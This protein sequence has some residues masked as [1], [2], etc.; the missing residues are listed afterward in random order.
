MGR[1][2]F[3][4]SIVA[5]RRKTKRSRQTLSLPLADGTFS[6]GAERFAVRRGARVCSPSRVGPRQPSEISAGR[7]TSPD[8]AGLR[9][10][11]LPLVFLKD[12]IIIFFSSVLPHTS[13]SA[14]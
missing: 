9:H 10:S 3:T 4:I 1:N 13:V 6:L 14:C 12:F 11:Q 2:K 5:F 8:L 7:K